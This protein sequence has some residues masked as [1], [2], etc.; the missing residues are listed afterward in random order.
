M[1]QVATKDTTKDTT[2]AIGPGPENVNLYGDKGNFGSYNG[3]F[4]SGDCNGNKP[5]YAT[6]DRFT[7]KVMAKDKTNPNLHQGIPINK[8]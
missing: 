1:H 2:Q 5:K 7:G 6:S 8:K 3:N 4:G